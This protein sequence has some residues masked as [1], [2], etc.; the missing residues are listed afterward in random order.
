MNDTI[1]DALARHPGTCLA[2]VAFT[3]SLIFILRSA[4]MDVVE[5]L[6]VRWW[7]AKV[8][9]DTMGKEAVAATLRAALKSVTAAPQAHED[10]Q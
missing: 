4:A 10:G 6:A 1:I 9:A 3:Y 7:C 5:Q 8:T 2:L